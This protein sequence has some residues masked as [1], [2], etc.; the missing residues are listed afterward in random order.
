MSRLLEI[1][2]KH[3]THTRPRLCGTTKIATNHLKNTSALLLRAWVLGSR[4]CWRMSREHG[5]SM[6]LRWLTARS[7]PWAAKATTISCN[8]LSAK[9]STTKCHFWDRSQNSKILVCQ[10]PNW[11]H[12]AS[13]WFQSNASKGRGYLKRENKTSMF[14]WWGL[15]KYRSLRKFAF[16][17]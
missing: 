4:L 1:N 6:R 11:C 9:Y 14:T 15:V 8:P 2:T 13:T 10:D 5:S 3:W 12:C 17:N 7:F 16:P